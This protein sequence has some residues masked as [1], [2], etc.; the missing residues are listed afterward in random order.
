MSLLL[1]IND[2]TVY[3]DGNGVRY[4]A[5]FCAENYIYSSKNEQK[6]L[7]PVCAKTSSNKVV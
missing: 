2:P 1:G 3:T 6:L 5:W 7:P 4:Q